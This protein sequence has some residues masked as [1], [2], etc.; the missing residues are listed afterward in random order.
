LQKSCVGI[1][2]ERSVAIKSEEK[3][4][5]INNERREHAL[6]EILSLQDES[7]GVDGRS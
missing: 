2:K 4:I 1:K 5:Q 3:E 7:Q 6:A